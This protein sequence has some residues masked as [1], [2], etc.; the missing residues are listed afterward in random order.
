MFTDGRNPA[1]GKAVIVNI[2]SWVCLGVDAIG[3]S[4]IDT[5][6]DVLHTD[7]GGADDRMGGWTSTAAAEMH[8]WK[9]ACN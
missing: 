6:T 5:S 3:R 9:C 1:V 8:S 7:C 2:A 4:S